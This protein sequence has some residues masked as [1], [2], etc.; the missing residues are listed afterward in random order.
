MSLCPDYLG[1]RPNRPQQRGPLLPRQRDSGAM[2]LRQLQSSSLRPRGSEQRHNVPAVLRE[3]YLS[4][5]T[6]EEGDAGRRR[7][8]EGGGPAVLGVVGVH[9]LSH[10]CVLRG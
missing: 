5:V 2:E 10:A 1:P 9:A 3:R 6:V 8:G 7:A 4:Y